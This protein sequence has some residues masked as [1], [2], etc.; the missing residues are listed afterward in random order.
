M[1]TFNLSKELSFFIFLL[2][3]YSKSENITP[4]Q[5]Y[6]QFRDAGLLEYINSM[7]FMYHQESPDNAIADI[8]L[9]LASA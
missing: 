4:V 6:D 5:A 9:R 7:Y 1:P 2:G 8:K 3:K